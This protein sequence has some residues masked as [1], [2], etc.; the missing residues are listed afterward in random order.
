MPELL[1]L[2]FIALMG[3]WGR[4]RWGSV[5]A[6]VAVATVAV[7]G[8]IIV[9]PPSIPVGGG[10]G[11]GGGGGAGG[12]TANLWVDT[13]GGTCSRSGS[14]VS[15]VDASACGSF[16]AAYDT[17][18]C[19][20][21]VLV[22]S[23][24]YGT[25][26][27]TGSKSCSGWSG[28]TTCSGCVT[29]SESDGQSASAGDL[30]QSASYATFTGINFGFMQFFS[31]ADH[32]IVDGTS[33]GNFNIFGSDDITFQNS[34]FNGFTTIAQNNIWDDPAGD[35]ADR[36]Y[37]IGNSFQNFYVAS[38]P[39]VHAEGLYVGFSRDGLIRGNTFTNNGN[40]AHIFFTWFGNLAS[41]PAS[42]PTGWCVED[43]VFNNTW[44]AFF[45]INFRDEI[46]SSTSGI[47]VESGNVNNGP[48]AFIDDVTHVRNC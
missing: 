26:T 47:D 37:L 23:G 10:G 9:G 39:S 33:T 22:R 19:G 17:A 3:A 31:A 27:M 11:G 20:D 34:S 8:S 18:S 24:S 41:P 16:D 40:T 7:A 46:S 43:N 14:L 32:I 5:A 1:K 44:T 21:K 2:P 25:Q 48:Q 45:S 29:F 6:T 13:N 4:G 28:G 30:Y 38:N 12:T 36:V 35:A 15:Y 42:N